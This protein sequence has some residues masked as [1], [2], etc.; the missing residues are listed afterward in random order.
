MGDFNTLDE[1]LSA[2]SDG[3]ILS[4]ITTTQTFA[5]LFLDSATNDFHPILGSA[6]L[7]AGID[8]TSEGLS[9]PNDH[10]GQSRPQGERYDI[11]AYELH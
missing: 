7:D 11:G 2:I 4:N 10:D 8:P 6:L 3:T 5:E 1:S 9:I